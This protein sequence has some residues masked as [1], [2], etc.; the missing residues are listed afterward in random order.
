MSEKQYLKKKLPHHQILWVG[1]ENKRTRVREILQEI[2][3]QRL[4]TLTEP[5]DFFACTGS[6]IWLPKRRSGERFV[7]TYTTANQVAL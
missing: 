2:T 5:H 4:L 6:A 7:V 1:R 3:L